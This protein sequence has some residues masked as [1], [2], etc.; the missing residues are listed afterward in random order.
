MDFSIKGEHKVVLFAVALAPGGNVAASLRAWARRVNPVDICLEAG[1]PSGIYLGYFG[2]KETRHLA[3]TFQ[4]GLTPLFASLPPAIHLGVLIKETGGWFL[5]A[6][7]DLAP[8]VK[9]ALSLAQQLGLEPL[10]SPALSAGPGYFVGKH[11][12]TMEPERFSFRHLDVLLMRIELSPGPAEA[13]AWTIISR[14]RR[15]VGSG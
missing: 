1:L 8:A 14:V 6:E 7:E 4:A 10:P 12:T 9:A 15:L 2:G 5:E 3:K 11:V 13:L